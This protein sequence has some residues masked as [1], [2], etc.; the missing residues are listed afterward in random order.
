MTQPTRN[1]YQISSYVAPD[2]QPA[3]L[4]TR[5]DNQLPTLA[6]IAIRGAQ[7]GYS[8]QDDNAITHAKA[9]LLVS[10]AYIA[11][12]GMITLGLLLI[13]WLFK[14]LGERF[15]PYAYT[16]L[17]VWGVAC[18]LALWGNRRQALHHT[19]SGIAHHELDVR[20]RV[21]RHAIDTHAELLI[22]QWELQ[23]RDRKR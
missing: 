12:A 2:P 10:A 11:A 21:A 4:A 15:A 5:T 20:E 7:S 19:P 16:G 17:V 22:R 9:T 18:L 1:R 14:G 6:D 8:R 13:V 3:P 23:N